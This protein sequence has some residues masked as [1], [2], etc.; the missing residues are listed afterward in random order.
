VSCGGSTT[1]LGVL[2][3]DSGAHTIFIIRNGVEL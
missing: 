1:L 3:I 2:S